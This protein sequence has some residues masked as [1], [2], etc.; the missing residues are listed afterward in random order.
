MLKT[1]RNT[2]NMGRRVERAAAKILNTRRGLLYSFFEHG[3]W[4][5]QLQATGAIYS[6]CD[7]QGGGAVD[8]FCLEQVTEGDAE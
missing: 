4:W 3:Q 2:R 5:I 1:E 7:A 6:V 8:G